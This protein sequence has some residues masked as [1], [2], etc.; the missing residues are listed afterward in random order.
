MTFKRRCRD[1]NECEQQDAGTHD[2][3]QNNAL[4]KPNS[5]LIA[6]ED[7]PERFLFHLFTLINQLF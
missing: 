1:D 5:S 7:S 6:L 2:G 3:K 4:P